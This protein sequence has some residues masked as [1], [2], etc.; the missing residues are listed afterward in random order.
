MAEEKELTPAEVA[1]LREI[2]RPGLL[3]PDSAVETQ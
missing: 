2:A 3:N 1:A